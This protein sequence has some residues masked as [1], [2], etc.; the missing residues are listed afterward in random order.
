MVD[1]I[2][3]VIAC[4]MIGGVIGFICAALCVIAGRE[5]HRD[6]IRADD[7]E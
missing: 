1:T 7:A 6:G 2:I 3:L 4:A 5:D